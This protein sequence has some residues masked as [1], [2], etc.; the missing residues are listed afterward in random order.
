V[1]AT[2]APEFK[3]TVQRSVERMVEQCQALLDGPE[4]VRL[5]FPVKG[6]VGANRLIL[7]S[8]FTQVLLVFQKFRVVAAT[9]DE[10]LVFKAG[11]FT[12]TKPS[13]LLRTLPRDTPLTLGRAGVLQ[14][15]PE[16][17]RVERTYAPVV[18]AVA[19]A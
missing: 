19:E 16:K 10:L 18:A 11:W 3:P 7:V 12:R 1:H 13:E 8:W 17:V 4:V 5:A 6:G 14:L 9:D 15:G 2:P